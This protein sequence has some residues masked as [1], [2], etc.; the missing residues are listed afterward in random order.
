MRLAAQHLGDSDEPDGIIEVPKS[1]QPNLSISVEAKGSRGII[2]HKELSEATVDRHRK[3]QGCTH[4]IAIARE[5]ARS[6]KGG[7]D[8]ALL[9]ENE[10]KIPL[11]TVAG[12]TKL[13]R[14]HRSRPFTYDKIEKIL[15]TWKHPDETED[16]IEA[17]QGKPAVDAPRPAPPLEP[18]KKE[19]AR[20]PPGLLGRRG[21][22]RTTHD[23]GGERGERVVV[24][25]LSGRI[26]CRTW[27][28]PRACCP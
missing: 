18:A 27:R 15:T 23:R 17:G 13:L 28:C 3:E 14:L 26:R 19:K 8:S 6:G 7:K 4:A 20:A 9:R 25:S 12:L 1:G 22:L 10:G 11:I 24:F 16:F 21:W 2:T 5:F